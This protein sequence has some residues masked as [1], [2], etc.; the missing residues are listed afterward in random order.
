MFRIFI[1]YF[2][3][4]SVF[5][6]IFCSSLCGFIIISSPSFFITPFLIHRLLLP[7]VSTLLRI[8][9]PLLRIPSLFLLT[10]F[11][12]QP[13][14]P[15]SSASTTLSL[16]FFG[17]FSEFNSSLSLVFPFFLKRISSL[18]VP[19]FCRLPA[20]TLQRPTPAPWQH[21]VH[22]A[23]PDWTPS[24]DTQTHYRP[25]PNLRHRNDVYLGLKYRSALMPLRLGSF[26]RSQGE[27]TRRRGWA[28]RA[29]AKEG[30]GNVRCEEVR[31]G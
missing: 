8:L 18:S 21:L 23:K 3:T 25:R 30:K 31:K 26:T 4:R 15:H 20:S 10:I 22:D 17:T 2:G 5:F 19:S 14:L 24:G 6:V 28:E 16:I 9:S 13:L 1:T 11:S 27:E 29:G 7:T 12:Q